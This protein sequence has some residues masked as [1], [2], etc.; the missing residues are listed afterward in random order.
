MKTKVVKIK[1][2]GDDSYDVYIGRPSMWGNPFRIG[3]DGSREEV[4]KKYETWIR[5]QT[6]LMKRLPT[7]EGQRLGCWCKPFP[8]H[9]DVLVRLIEKRRESEEE[10]DPF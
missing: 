9:G 8:C 4:I 5:T 7:L 1:K 2:L 10:K 3:R 6:H